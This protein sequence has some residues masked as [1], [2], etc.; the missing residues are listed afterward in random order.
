M[1]DVAVILFLTICGAVS[2]NLMLRQGGCV[3]NDPSF[4][5]SVPARWG[6]LNPNTAS[7]L[8]NDACGGYFCTY[9]KA[10][11]FPSFCVTN[12]AQVC[13]NAGVSVP[14]ACSTPV[15]GQCLITDPSAVAQ[16]LSRCGGNNPSGTS[17]CNDNCGGYGC[18]YYKTNNFSSS[19][20]TNV[21]QLCR[22]AGLPVPSTCGASVLTTT[23]KGLLV[24]VLLLAALIVV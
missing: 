16:V 4:V 11:L 1:K 12:I 19:C 20:V 22:N 23:I 21:A 24:A 9:L 14:A 17:L 2:A 3:I 5:A 7:A 13:R 18:T 10:N 8:C 15:Q 6:S